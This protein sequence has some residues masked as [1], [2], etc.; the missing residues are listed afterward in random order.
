[1]QIR[2]FD[3]SLEKFI[4]SLEKETIAKVLRV[5]DLLELFDRNLKLP[6]SKKITRDIFELRIRGSQEIR[7]LYVFHGSD[8]ILL[9]GFIK[10]SQKIPRKEISIAIQRMKTLD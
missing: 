5:V 7:I 9:N 1:M 10:K 4:K 3:G 6:H 2:F 8:I